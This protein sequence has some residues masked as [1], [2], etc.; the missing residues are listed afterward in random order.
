M[1]KR[2]ELLADRSCL[3]DFVTSEK[4]NFHAAVL[5]GEGSQTFR[6]VGV[7]MVLRRMGIRVL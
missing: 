1:P 5:D 3:S 7:T 2:P 4:A 6:E